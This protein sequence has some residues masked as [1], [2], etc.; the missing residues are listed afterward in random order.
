MD[1]CP[2]CGSTSW[3]TL[4]GGGAG[5]FQWVRCSCALVFKR[6]EP[7]SAGSV[8]PDAARA[9]APASGDG[10]YFRRYA[11]RRR[12]RIAKSRRQILDALDVAP[13]G[14]LLD[15]GCSLG[16]TLE[17]AHRL[18][19]DAIGVDVSDHAVA[20]CRRL[21]LTACSGTLEALPVE[22]ASVAVA[23]LKHVFEHTLAPRVALAELRRVLL[24]GAAVFFAVPNAGYFQA[25]RSPARSRFFR[26]EAGRAH[27]IYYLPAT[28]SRLLEEEGFRVERIHPRLLHH[29]AGIIRRALELA[30]L[31]LR[32]P[33]RAAADRLGLRK[34]FWLVAVR[35]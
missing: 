34:E 26:G 10:A 33:L 1:E 13:P 16:Y 9:A 21:G 2:L 3:T 23:V 5:E 22:D 8:A 25:A 35:T 12:R 14:R 7:A 19:L 20:E 28:L 11:R 29:R 24:P 32:V 17:A 6:S 18:G 27:Y 30:M 4:A 15:V 31:P